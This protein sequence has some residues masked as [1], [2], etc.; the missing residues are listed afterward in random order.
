MVYVLQQLNDNGVP[1]L[2]AD[3]ASAEQWQMKREGIRRIWMEYLG[4]HPNRHPAG[5]EVLSKAEFAGHSRL[6]IRYG[7]ANGDEVTAYL[8]LPSDRRAGPL[9]AVLALHPTIGNGKEDTAT[10]QGRSN[11]RYGLELAQRGYVVLAPDTITAG[12]R[13]SSLSEAYRTAAFYESN[14]GWTAVGK[15][16]IDHLYGVDL[17]CTLS[18]VDPGRIGA[19]GHSLGGYNSFFLAGLDDRVRAFVSSCGF[20]TFTGD[21]TPNR[22]G[23]R[24]WFSH[25]P[26]LSEDLN[27]GEV[28]FEFH[29]IAALAAPIPA[30][31]YSGQQDL[32]FPNWQSYSQGMERLFELY[33]LLDKA[34]SFHYVMTNGGHDFPEAVRQMAYA[35]LDRHL[36]KE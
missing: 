3:A 8:L 22:W 9:P 20:C 16:L 27:K 32:I 25:I 36:G 19:I 4:E 23:H 6:H 7:T 30:F 24:D 34:D 21:P 14:P 15:M 12:E 31:Y 1:P 5:Y 13:A 33:R 35:F 26:R 11:R 17:L 10:V 2:L 18:E 29:E 28:P